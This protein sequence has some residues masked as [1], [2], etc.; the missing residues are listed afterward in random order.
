MTTDEGAMLSRE[1]LRKIMC[2]C[3]PTTT[4]PDNLRIEYFLDIVMHQAEEACPA[5]IAKGRELQR[6]S[7]IEM[8]KEFGAG[9]SFSAETIVFMLRNNTGELP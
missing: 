6:A 1:K 4:A 5:G 9:T 8:F 3:F 7:D 2:E